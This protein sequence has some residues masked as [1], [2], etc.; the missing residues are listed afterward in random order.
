M[1]YLLR[2]TLLMFSVVV[3]PFW[4]ISGLWNGLRDNLS[5]FSAGFKMLW[6]GAN[7]R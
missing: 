6:R 2:A 3:L 7:V 1:K 5:I 4:V